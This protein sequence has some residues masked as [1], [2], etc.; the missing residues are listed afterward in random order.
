MVAGDSQGFEL[1]LLIY[2]DMVFLTNLHYVS[3]I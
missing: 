1:V 3:N 2:Q